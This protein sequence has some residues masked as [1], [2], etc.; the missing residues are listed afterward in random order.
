RGR[1]ARADRVADPAPAVLHGAALRRRARRAAEDGVAEGAEIQAEDTAA[2]GDHLGPGGGRDPAAPGETHDK[3]LTMLL[4]FTPEQEE[5]RAF[6]R[7]VADNRIDKVALRE[8]D[9]KKIFP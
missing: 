8:A 1:P 7:D 3:G 5:L 4:E 2:D 9:E 6:V